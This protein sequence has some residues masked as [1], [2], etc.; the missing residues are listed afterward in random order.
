MPSQI[1][2][3]NFAKYGTC[4]ALLNLAQQEQKVDDAFSAALTLY[5][6]QQGFS[7]TQW[8]L[9]DKCGRRDH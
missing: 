3:E 4:K 8:N 1:N 5:I 9:D 7:F 6:P 2:N